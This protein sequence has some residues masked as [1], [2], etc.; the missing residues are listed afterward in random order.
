[1]QAEP[2]T[3]F[4]ARMYPRLV[5]QQEFLRAQRRGPDGLISIVHPWESGMDNSPCWDLPLQ[6]VEPMPDGVRRRDLT[7]V[8]A[9][10]RP[11]DRDYERY[12][13]L[14]RAYRDTGYRR[15]CA[16]SV[17]DPLFNA[18]YGIA[19]R[20]LADIAAEIGRDPEP[21]RAEAAATT[22][23]MVRHLYQDGLFH[24]RD[25]LTGCLVR[26][27]SAAGLV[28]LILPD[29]PREI[30]NA[31]IGTGLD[32][33]GL[34]EGVL[35]SYSPAASAEFDPVRYWRGPSWINLSWLVWQGLKDRRPDLGAALAE[36]MI[37]LV[38]RSGFREYFG[39]HTL[40][41]HGSHDFS[42]SAALILDVVAEH[43]LNGVPLT[44]REFGQQ[45]RTFGEAHHVGDQV[46]A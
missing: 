8:S 46:P 13:A 31:L 40:E 28:P 7:H 5:A 4:L 22:E 34:K 26:S 2:D 38:T 20:T 42:W 16:F 24:P 44:A 25:A 23:A 19:E 12:V 35:P 3:A 1:H 45:A 10:E 37:D 17:E 18:A 36:A 9:A 43:G 21:H 27:A 29:L 32:L 41:G 11:T 33:F 15:A 14:A 6:A 39:P 30:A